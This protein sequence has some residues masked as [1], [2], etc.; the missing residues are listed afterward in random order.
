MTSRLR[1]AL[2]QLG[3][4]PE[5]R[6]S[7]GAAARCSRSR[8]Q[9]RDRAGRP[10]AMGAAGPADVA[11]R[12]SG[13]PLPWQA[14]ARAAGSV[15]AW[16]SLAALPQPQGL[17]LQWSP[18]ASAVD[19]DEALTA[20]E[21]PALGLRNLRANVERL[22]RRVL[23]PPPAVKGADRVTATEDQT[24]GPDP[25]YTLRCTAGR[26]LVLLCASGVA[27]NWSALA[28]VAELQLAR[29]PTK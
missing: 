23:Q 25:V 14:A 16:R 15:T 28:Q 8:E 10:S 2:A 6:E 11:D 24:T 9:R 5:S 7:P 29:M 22:E 1:F 4:K 12:C 13:H 20:A 27:W 3:F 26:H 19:A 18:M 21:D 17:W